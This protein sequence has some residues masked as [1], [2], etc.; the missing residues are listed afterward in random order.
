MALRE[1][2]PEL[3]IV[4]AAD[5][6]GCLRGGQRLGHRLAA[7]VDLRGDGSGAGLAAG[8]AVTS[9]GGSPEQAARAAAEAAQNAG[10]TREEVAQIAG[11]AAGA[12]V[13][14]RASCSTVTLTS[15]RFPRDGPWIPGAAA[16]RVLSCFCLAPPICGT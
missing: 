10:A 7:V 4:G 11:E 16:T 5:G 12:A 13:V 3:A 6:R 15:I 2:L 14:A 8:A 9:A 1:R